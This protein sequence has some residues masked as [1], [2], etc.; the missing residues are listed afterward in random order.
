[1]IKSQCSQTIWSSSLSFDLQ[2]SHDSANCGPLSNAKESEI[3][4]SFGSGFFTSISSALY[5]STELYFSNMVISILQRGQR[6]WTLVHPSMHSIQKLWQQFYGL[7]LSEILSKQ[8][9]HWWS[10]SL[11][12]TSQT[13]FDSGVN[14]DFWSDEILAFCYLRCVF[15]PC[16]FR[17]SCLERALLY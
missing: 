5:G 3:S 2:N 11:F 14:S 13:V 16:I 10:N 8:M 4:Y 1:M 9:Q 12:E 15:R 17:W 6:L 7:A